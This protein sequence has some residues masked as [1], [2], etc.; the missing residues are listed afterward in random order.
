MKNLWKSSSLEYRLLSD[1]ELF[2]LQTGSG[3]G[4]QAGESQGARHGSKPGHQLYSTQGQVG[5]PGP[6]TRRRLRPG[7]APP[8]PVR[9]PGL[10]QGSV[11]EEGR[12]AAERKDVVGGWMSREGGE[13]RRGEGGAG[14]VA[15][16]ARCH[17]TCVATC[18][19]SC[20]VEAED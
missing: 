14:G 19:P 5:S 4:T 12:E 10:R 13:A 7:A 17:V 3:L 9:Y 1:A 18:R 8:P 11:R 16:R 15:E 2:E 6:A 20:V